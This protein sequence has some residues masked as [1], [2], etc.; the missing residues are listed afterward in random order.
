[1]IMGGV[2]EFMGLGAA[3]LAIGGIL[4][5]ALAVLWVIVIRSPNIKRP[6]IR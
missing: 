6:D 5:T 1:M 2:I 4:T 3:F